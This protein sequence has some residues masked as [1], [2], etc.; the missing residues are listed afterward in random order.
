MECA[1]YNSQLNSFYHPFQYV[2]IKLL[3]HILPYYNVK[4]FHF[5][6]FRHIP[7]EYLSDFC[8]EDKESIEKLDDLRERVRKSGLE[9]Y[10]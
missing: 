4:I 6:L 5:H 3:F 10:E 1:I 7:Q 8:C 2:F 9:Q